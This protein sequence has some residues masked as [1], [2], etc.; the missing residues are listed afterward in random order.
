MENNKRWLYLGAGTLLLVFCGLIYGW[1]LF[2]A[3]F[4]EVYPEWTLSQLSMTFTISMIFFCIGSFVAG[5]LSAKLN[6]NMIIRIA[7]ALLLIGFFGVS[8]M[9]PEAGSLPMLYICYGVCGGSGVGLTYN[10]IIGTMNKWFP[11]KPGLASG[12]MMMG[13]GL[14]AL[15]LGSIAGMEVYL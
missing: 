5:K 14:G 4:G 8:R 15:I 3:P 1:S 6:P 11:D 2:R 7:A 13:F 10:C 12:I 9:N